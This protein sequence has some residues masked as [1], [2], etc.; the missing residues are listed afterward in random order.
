[1][2]YEKHFD[3]RTRELRLFGRRLYFAS[4]SQ[5]GAG[6][7]SQRTHTVPLPWGCKLQLHVPYRQ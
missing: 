1:M 6:R 7:R 3:Y 5:T 2:G 4:D